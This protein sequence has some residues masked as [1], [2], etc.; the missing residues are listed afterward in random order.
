MKKNAFIVLALFCFTEVSACDICGCGVGGYYIGILPE[1]NKHVYGLRYRLNS[2]KTHIGPG[3][4]TTYL[5]SEENYQTI[6]MW[7]G[8]NIGSR[9]RLMGA[10]PYSINERVNQCITNTKNRIS[11]FSVS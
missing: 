3:G 2:I 11:D 8:W 1:F 7:G 9:F 10:A 4:S 5:T 6:E